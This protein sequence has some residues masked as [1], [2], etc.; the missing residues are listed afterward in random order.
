[1]L[2][3]NPTAGVMMLLLSASRELQRAGLPLS[4][5]SA[6][7]DPAVGNQPGCSRHFQVSSLQSSIAYQE[8]AGDPFVK[9]HMS[10]QNM[11]D[12]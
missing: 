2:P 7:G 8:V 12:L 6:L 11:T 4:G 9:I 10:G 5:S 3:C 1:M